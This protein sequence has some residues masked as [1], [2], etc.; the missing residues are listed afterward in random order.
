MWVAAVAVIA[1]YLAGGFMGGDVVR[2]FAGGGDL[3]AEG[4]GNVGAT[5]ALRV[6]GPAFASAVLAVDVGKGLVAVLLIPWLAALTG[7]SAASFHPGALAF[8]CGAA[9]AFGHCFPLMHRFRGGK[10][11][12]TLAGVFAV[13][14]PWVFLGMFIAFVLVVVTSGYVALG[15]LAAAA[16]AVIVTLALRLAFGVT[17]IGPAAMAFAVAMAAL[18]VVRHASNI[19]RLL[20]HTEARM[21]G[22]RVIGRAIDRWVGR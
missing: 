1:A 5:N 22:V 4:S 13:L 8:A 6:R 16:A 12:A 18:V 10:S 21:D 19:R 20:A 7:P 3:R 11:V 2:R 17:S 9:V 15:S 14:L